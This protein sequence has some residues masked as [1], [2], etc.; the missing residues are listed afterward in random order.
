VLFSP[1]SVRIELVAILVE[2]SGGTETFH[3]VNR[4]VAGSSRGPAQGL[5]SQ[6]HFWFATVYG[7][8]V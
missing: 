2:R 6:S 8:F 1:K 5:A 4:T 3:T 7:V